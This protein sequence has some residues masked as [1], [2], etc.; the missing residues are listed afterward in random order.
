MGAHPVIDRFFRKVGIS[1]LIIT[2]ISL[3]MGLTFCHMDKYS[4]GDNDMLKQHQN[5]IVLCGGKRCCPEMTLLEDGKV[6]IKD[7]D[8]K[9]VTMEKSQALLIAEAVEQLEK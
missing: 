3:S 9:I 7:D 5:T 4:Q 2:I 8:G 1:L 6:Q